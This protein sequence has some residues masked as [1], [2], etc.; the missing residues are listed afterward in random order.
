MSHP[1]EL[2]HRES[3]EGRSARRNTPMRPYD[4]RRADLPITG[5]AEPVR[6]EVEWKGS[7]PLGRLN[8]PVDATH[9]S[10]TSC[11]YSS[12][13]GANEACERIGGGR[14]T[15]HQVGRASLSSRVKEFFPATRDANTVFV[16]SSEA[17]TTAGRRRLRCAHCDRD[18]I[19][20]QRAAM[21]GRFA[22]AKRAGER[23]RGGKTGCRCS[24][25]QPDRERNR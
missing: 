14:K 7:S 8:D 18:F 5:T 24:A 20:R 2:D 22:M 15:P 11:V 23:V 19:E 25:T 16:S 1:R 3:G 4:Q 9:N 6:V 13:R 10:S 12:D 21:T 17:N